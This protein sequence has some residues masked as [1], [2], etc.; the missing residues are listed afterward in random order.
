MGVVAVVGAAVGVVVVGV[1]G[2][3]VGCVC[4]CGGRKVGGGG[5][6]GGDACKRL[7][8]CSCNHGAQQCLRSV[9]KVAR[10]SIRKR[11]HTQR[12]GQSCAAHPYLPTPCASEAARPTLP[13][14]SAIPGSLYPLDH[15]SVHLYFKYAAHA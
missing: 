8:V 12:L 2:G 13:T 10:S 3:V 4:V 9:R 11:K 15:E 1:G 5:G 7:R 6:G 14:L